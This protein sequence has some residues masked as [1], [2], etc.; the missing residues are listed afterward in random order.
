[1]KRSPGVAI[2]PQ[3]AK[4]NGLRLLG[5]G[6]EARDGGHH[7]RLVGEWGQ[8]GEHARPADHRARVGLPD[9][10]R[11]VLLIG[12]HRRSRRAVAL[13]MHEGVGEAE[14]GP[15][16]AIVVAPDIVPELRASLGEVLVGGGVA[17]EH[18]VHEVRRPA[19]H[20][21]ILVGPELD[22]LA[23]AAQVVAR[24]RL[25]VRVADAL[26]APVDRQAEPVLKVWAMLQGVQRGDREGDAGS[27][28]RRHVRHPLAA[29]PDLTPV[30][31]RPK[32]G[33]GARL[34]AEYCD[35]RQPSRSTRGLGPHASPVRS[36]RLARS[37]FEDGP[38]V[39]WRRPR[40]A[41]RA[42]GA[43]AARASI[44]KSVPHRAGVFAYPQVGLMPA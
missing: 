2:G 5:V 15:Q 21:A 8:R 34:T 19:E 16:Q 28:V 32:S 26:P 3:K 42:L 1:M 37:A 30:A 43:L 36:T 41:A 23:P 20:A 33:R 14:V 22:H 27:E 24:P 11:G 39:S 10:A 13:R 7:G 18:H 12:R 44:S 38:G 6:R 40:S 17:G 4:A 29:E 35:C 9:D 31:Q 25:D